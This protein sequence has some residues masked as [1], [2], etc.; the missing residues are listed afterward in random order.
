MTVAQVGPYFERWSVILAL[1]SNILLFGSL[2]FVGLQVIEQ[3]KQLELQR[4]ANKYELDARAQELL[5][6]RQELKVQ[7]NGNLQ[8]FFLMLFENP[9]LAEAWDLGRKDHLTL[10]EIGQ[11]RLKWA[12]VY[13]FEHIAGIF[14][15]ANEGL[16]EVLDLEG[17]RRSLKDDFVNHVYP[18]LVHWWCELQE[19]YEEPFRDW[20][21]E[22][23]GFDVKCQ[24]RE[25]EG[26]HV[27]P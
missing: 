22:I 5:F 26:K 14:G 1:L 10:D 20:V 15:L 6:R 4:E 11:R 2:I 18:G 17:W 8:P 19:D 24:C 23:V 3:R 7:A 9:Q 25:C 21:H 16:M 12:C 13:W 27:V